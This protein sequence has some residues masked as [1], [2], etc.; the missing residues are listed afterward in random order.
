MPLLEQA[1]SSPAPTCLPSPS[2][3]HVLPGLPAPGP[4]AQ[5][6]RL[7]I[8]WEAGSLHAAF[9]AASRGR[10]AKEERGRGQAGRAERRAPRS[11]C[12]RL[13]QC[14]VSRKASVFA[15]R[16]LG[17]VLGAPRQLGPGALTRIL[18]VSPGPAACPVPETGHT[19][20]PRP[21]TSS[22][23]WSGGCRPAGQK[24][25]PTKAGRGVSGR[26]GSMM[27]GALQQPMGRMEP[28]RGHGWQP[29]TPA[30]HLPP[31]TPSVSP[32]NSGCGNTGYG[33]P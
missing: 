31:P 24:P 23:V 5:L 16:C 33:P 4:T 10:R 8:R 19:P 2:P 28:A 12:G 6:Q 20:P 1:Q 9:P 13:G 14:P 22:S 15:A 26:E 32:G 7:R 27:L 30:T 3:S 18:Q 29:P 21:R 11:T 17:R 25:R